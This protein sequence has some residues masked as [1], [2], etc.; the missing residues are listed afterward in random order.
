MKKGDRM[1]R[2]VVGE[3]LGIALVALLL[4]F[5]SP[6]PREMSALLVAA[7]LIVSGTVPS[8]QLLD[9]MK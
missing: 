6:F 5:A 1:H 2:W 4:L 3:L 8:R 7:F 9:A